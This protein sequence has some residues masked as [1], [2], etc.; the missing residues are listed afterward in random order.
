MPK[1]MET[2]VLDHQ[3]LDLASL[4]KKNDLEKNTGFQGEKIISVFWSVFAANSTAG[5]S[6]KFT[7]LEILDLAQRNNVLASRA[8]KK[9]LG[10]KLGLKGEK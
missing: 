8:K 4:A 10:K 6:P 2:L 7:M 1:M 3:N 5:N 9:R